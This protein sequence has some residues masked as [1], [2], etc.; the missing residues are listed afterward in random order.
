MRQ[1]TNHLLMW[2]ASV[3]RYGYS[4]VL[5]TLLNLLHAQTLCWK[6]MLW[7]FSPFILCPTA[8]QQC[9]YWLSAL[10]CCSHRLK[11]TVL[12]QDNDKL[13]GLHLNIADLLSK[14]EGPEQDVHQVNVLVPQN[15]L[16]SVTLWP[17]LPRF[18]PPDITTV[19]VCLWTSV[20]ARLSQKLCE[21]IWTQ[22]HQ[23]FFILA[24]SLTLV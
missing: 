2:S 6:P 24:F 23:S 21:R 13:L 4:I 15:P 1:N 8:L 10:K 9:D 12:K 3:L 19:C 22:Q 14:A 7:F 20:P 5:T 18:F 11:S 16:L 17:S